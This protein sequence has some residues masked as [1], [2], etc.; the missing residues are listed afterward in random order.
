MRK[1]RENEDIVTQ[2]IGCS[3]NNPSVELSYSP[4]QKWTQK[5]TNFNI[6]SSSMFIHTFFIL[7]GHLMGKKSLDS[8]SGSEDSSNMDNIPSSEEDKLLDRYVQPSKLVQDFIRI[9]GGLENKRQSQTQRQGQEHVLSRMGVLKTTK[10]EE[11]DR[12]R[13]LK[14]VSNGERLVSVR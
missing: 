7:L 14:Q 6:Q 13:Y 12:H 1:L 11:T 3:N 4:N 8:L 2:D 10:W 9:L 5:N